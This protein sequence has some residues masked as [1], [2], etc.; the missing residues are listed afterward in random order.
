MFVLHST[1]Q[2][3]TNNSNYPHF[4]FKIFIHAHSFLHFRNMYKILLLRSG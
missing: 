2:K 1:S 3:Y 4:T